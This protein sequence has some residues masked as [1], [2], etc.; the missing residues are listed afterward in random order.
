MPDSVTLWP[1]KD[2]RRKTLGFN[3]TQM[4]LQ[5]QNTWAVKCTFQLQPHKTSSSSSSTHPKRP[6]NSL[7]PERSFLLQTVNLDSFVSKEFSDEQDESRRRQKKLFVKSSL[8]DQ[9][10]PP[11]KKSTKKQ[12]TKTKETYKKARPSPCWLIPAHLQPGGLLRWVVGV[13]M[14]L[15]AQQ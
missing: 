1:L 4:C 9:T 7:R 14:A 6:R 13:M 3:L 8:L 11:L 12:K 2:G 15:N 10:V 5:L